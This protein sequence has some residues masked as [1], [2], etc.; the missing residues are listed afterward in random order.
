MLLE[1]CIEM[2]YLPYKTVLWVFQIKSELVTV[3]ISYRNVY[4]LHD[5]IL[6]NKSSSTLSLQPISSS[7]TAL[8]FSW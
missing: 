7:S 3:N 1:I 4:K 6:N 8:L 2:N 5:N